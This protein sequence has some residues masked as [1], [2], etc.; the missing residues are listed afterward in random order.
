MSTLIKQAN[1]L[2][3]NKLKLIWININLFYLLRKKIE[4]AYKN[5]KRAKYNLA[6]IAV[7]PTALKLTH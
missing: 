3:Y 5:L 7:S 6:I 2:K 1:L 4:G